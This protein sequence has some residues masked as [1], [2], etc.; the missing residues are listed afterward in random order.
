MRVAIVGATGAVGQELL[1]LLAERSF[2]LTS[3]RLFA[4]PRSAGQTRRFA[5]ET[6]T[7][8]AAP[9]RRRPRQRR[10]VLVGRRQRLE[11][12]RLALGAHGAVVID[13]TS[14]WRLDPRVPLVVPEV[15]ADAVRAHEGVIANPNC[16]TIIALM[17]LAPLHAAFGLRRVTVATYQA[18][19]GAGQAASSSS[20][21]D[22]R[23]ARRTTAA[24]ARRSRTR[25]RS[26][27]SATT[28]RSA[29]TATTRRSA[30]SAS[31]RA[32]SSTPRTCRC[33]PPACACR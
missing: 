17:A 9:R 7:V 30:S 26:T 12:A 23:R 8:E 24:A 3:L 6:L 33:P 5:G 11:G 21:A 19:S 10:G 15:N 2:P 27:C 14:A 31:S 16:S 32:R 25:S 18:V 1:E 4:S 28:P 13:N 29:T 22:P 20:R